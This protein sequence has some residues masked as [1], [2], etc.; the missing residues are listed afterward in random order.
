MW[1]LQGKSDSGRPIVVFGVERER[2]RG[3]MAG[4]RVLA[5][6][7]LGP[8]VSSGDAAFA[9]VCVESEAELRQKMSFARDVRV[10]YAEPE[11]EDSN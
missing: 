2:L 7:N 6:E 4:D 10:T 5:F 9:L 8:T 1:T 11:T 3:L